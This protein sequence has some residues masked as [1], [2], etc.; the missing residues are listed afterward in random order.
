MRV[1]HINAVPYG[2]TGRI[3]FQ[4][5]DL[6]QQ[7]G[8]TSLSTTGFTWVKA[9][10][11]DHFITSGLITKTLH[12]RLAQ[13]TGMMGCFSVGATLKLLH[14]IKK[15]KPDVIH[16]HNLH[17]WFVNLPMLFRFFRKENIP[18]VWTFHDCWAMTGHCAYFSM[19]E[20]Q[21]WKTGCHHCT[22]KQE[23]PR[24]LVDNTP[25]MWRQKKKWFTGVK[26]LTVVT[27]SRWLA[28]LVRE[29]F[30]KEMD[31]RVINNGI[32]P[33]VFRP[34]ES[35]FRKK[36]HCENQFLLLGVSYDWCHRKGMDVFLELE[37]R[38]DS[39]FRIVLVGTNEEIDRELPESII[40]IHRT[41][42]ARELAQIY[43]AADLFV[44]PT[45]EENYPTVN[46]ESLSCGTPVLTFRTGGS[47]EML[48]D[49]CGC[50]VDCGDTDAM[51]REILRIAQQRPYSEEA[52]LRRAED[53]CATDRFREYIRL[54]EELAAQ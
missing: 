9:G 46:M 45:R 14:R 11:E 54:Y 20:C 43:S 1:F 33:T 39:G 47:P 23:Y 50:V 42:D 48:D 27:P 53:F 17:T 10:R 7:Q 31:V 41:A 44:N 12:M 5:M 15:F 52:C 51:E 38:L 3:M 13:A 29:S 16:V 22:Q 19:A 8:H 24:T 30:L 49:T 2:S 35:D 36:Y 25:W 18:V 6:L 21:K 4:I 37:K 28:G 34:Q 40:S 32:D 26:N